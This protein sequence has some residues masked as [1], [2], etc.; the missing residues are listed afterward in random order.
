MGGLPGLDYDLTTNTE[1]TLAQ[2]AVKHGGPDSV[3]HLVKLETFNCWNVEDSDGDTPLLWA[4][5][6]GKLETVKILLTCPRV[7]HTVK[8]SSGATFMKIARFSH[9]Y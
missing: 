5:K 2:V 6:N 7:D 9:F 3:R 8:D 1:V 4:M